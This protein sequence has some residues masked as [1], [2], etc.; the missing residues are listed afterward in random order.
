M[1]LPT[2]SD[3]MMVNF[4]EQFAYIKQLQNIQEAYGGE[5]LARIFFFVVQRGQIPHSAPRI[6]KN[7]Q[8]W[9]MSTSIIVMT[10]FVLKLLSND[11]LEN[12]LE[13][14]PGIERTGTTGINSFLS[15]VIPGLKLSFM[16]VTL[17]QN[18]SLAGGIEVY[19][20]D[21]KHMA[22]EIKCRVHQQ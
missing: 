10:K 8:K 22:S 7:F 16:T 6:D 14:V 11:W 4:K 5:G 3:F 19:V 17:K 12:C 20:P 21:Q 1:S 15:E 9:M 18:C 2:L 13:C